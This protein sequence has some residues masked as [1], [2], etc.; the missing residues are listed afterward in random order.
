MSPKNN[1]DD[2]SKK[3]KSLRRFLD[4]DDEFRGWKKTGVKLLR[5]KGGKMKQEKFVAKLKKI[6]KLSDDYD[7]LE[8]EEV[9]TDE[10]LKKT[11][12]AEI[13]KNKNKFGK[14]NNYIRL[15]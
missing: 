9:P 15:L 4:E 1:E 14:E 3:K 8:E 6:Y 7:E 10:Q 5:E 12:V 11:I 2:K 13:E